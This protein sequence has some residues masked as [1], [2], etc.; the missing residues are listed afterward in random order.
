MKQKEKAIA[1]RLRKKGKS[2]NFI[3]A[4][5]KVSKST[6]SLWTK[7]IQL[8]ELQKKRLKFNQNKKEVIEKRRNSRLSNE[9]SRRELVVQ[10]AKKGFTALSK[11]ELKIIGS[12]LYWAEG[13][14][15]QRGLVRFSNG[16]P[17]MIQVMMKFFRQI[18]EVKEERFRG[19]IHIH[20]HLNKQ[21][22]EIYWSKIS[23]IPLKQFFKTYNKPNKSSK[24]IRDSLPHG[25]FDIYVCDTYLF[26]NMQ[27]WREKIQQLYLNS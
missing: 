4:V 18:C 7:D 3:H 11:Q 15:T 14:K 25:T 13:G 6:L 22:A 27:G 9:L 16:D 1:I 19:Y 17:V 2:L 24:N 20:P 23:K 10:E 12:M 8:S 5:L 21:K 26:L